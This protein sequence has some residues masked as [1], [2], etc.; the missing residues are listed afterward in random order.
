[1]KDRP[2]RDW[3]AEHDPLAVVQLIDPVVD[4]LG[5]DARSVYAETY[6]TSALGPTSVMLLRRISAWLETSPTGFTL[7]LAPTAAA[8]GVSY[9]GGANSPLVR[10]LGRLVVFGMA[11]IRGDALA[12]RRVL[13][14]LA[15]RHLTRLPAYLAERHRIEFEASAG[16]RSLTRV[17]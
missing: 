13:P 6:W 10:T 16:S 9:G 5:H 15:R 8:L 2:T 1:M 11:E 14:P 12:V 7:P 17:G 4:A 3:I